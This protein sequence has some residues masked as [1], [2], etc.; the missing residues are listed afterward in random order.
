MI[1]GMPPHAPQ[2]LRRHAPTMSWCLSTLWTT[3][4]RQVVWSGYCNKA[5]PALHERPSCA[6]AHPSTGPG[7][8]FLAGS[9]SSGRRPE[10]AVWLG[11]RWSCR[12]DVLVAAEL[13]HCCAALLAAMQQQSRASVT[14]RA[15]RLG[16]VQPPQETTFCTAVAAIEVQQLP[17]YTALPQ[18]C[19]EEELCTKDRTIRGEIFTRP[20][21]L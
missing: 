17:W 5:C 7:M 13:K 3:A 12:F 19:L 14:E 8:S 21:S 16:S 18:H 6:A 2:A 1:L 20:D 4:I 9:S 10:P 11:G 15:G